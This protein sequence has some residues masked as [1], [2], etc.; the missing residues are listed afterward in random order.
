MISSL[1]QIYVIKSALKYI[2][3]EIN[4]NCLHVFLLSMTVADFL[5]TGKF[6]AKFLIFFLIINTLALCYPIELAPRA[7][8]IQKFPMY[9]N[10]TMHVFCWIAIIASSLSLMFLNLDKLFYFRFPFQ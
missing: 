6:L 1:L 10:A 8:L 7:G 3:H 4:E 9:L 5:L 2:R